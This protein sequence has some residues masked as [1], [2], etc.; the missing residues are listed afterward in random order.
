MLTSVIY[1]TSSAV[2]FKFKVIDRIRTFTNKGILFMIIFTIICF[3][4]TFFPSDAIMMDISTQC[5]L[6]LKKRKKKKSI[7]VIL[8]M[9]KLSIFACVK[10]DYL[11]VTI[12]F[13]SK[14]E[15]GN[16]QKNTLF[17]SFVS[18]WPFAQSQ[19][20]KIKVFSRELSIYGWRFP[21]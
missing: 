9:L 15:N 5:K 4:F 17:I 12:V 18:C 21:C 6:F 16:T 3:T 1:I 10:T 14:W 20:C 11:S 2:K 13:S 7:L 19:Y 8:C